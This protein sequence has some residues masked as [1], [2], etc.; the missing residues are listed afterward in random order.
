[1]RDEYAQKDKDDQLSVD[2]RTWVIDNARSVAWMG[3]R[4]YGETITPRRGAVK[5]KNRRSGLTVLPASMLR[6][7][8][9]EVTLV[10]GGDGNFLRECYGALC[11]CRLYVFL[12]LV[13]QFR[14]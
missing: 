13:A 1:M 7:S 5:E 11:Q 2:H 10:P 9:F 6:S 4:N 8:D 12:F 14:P 3:S